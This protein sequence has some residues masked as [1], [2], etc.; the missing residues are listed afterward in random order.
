[1]AY[2]AAKRRIFAYQRPEA[3]DVAVLGCDDPTV[4]AMVPAA[5]ARVSCFG[6]R[7]GVTHGATLRDGW[8]G[9]VAGDRWQPV[10]PAVEVAQPGPPSPS[11][12]SGSRAATTRASLSMSWPRSR[13]SGRCGP[14][15]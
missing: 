5:P 9:L 14:W 6:L 12:W 10:R 7:E 1:A 11:R 3:G 8:V 13:C 4:R 2:E 15:C